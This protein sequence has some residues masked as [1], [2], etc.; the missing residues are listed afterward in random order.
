MKTGKAVPTLKGSPQMA[1][2]T[3]RHWKE[4]KLTLTEFL[5]CALDRQVPTYLILNQHGGVDCLLIPHVDTE[6]W[7]AE[8][9]SSGA[10]G[11]VCR[12]HAEIKPGQISNPGPNFPW[13]SRPFPPRTPEA[14][15]GGT[16]G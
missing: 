12:G 6:V 4:R 7:K 13:A 14:V 8:T 5:L 1:T 3:N 11:T 16:C 10:L 2:W 15:S 9:R